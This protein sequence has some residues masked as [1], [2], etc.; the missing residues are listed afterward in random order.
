[1]GGGYSG[2]RKFLFSLTGCLCLLNRMDS[3]LLILPALIESFLLRGKENFRK[4]F[5]PGVLGMSPFA[6]WELF[7]L[8]Y[9]GFPFPNTAYAKLSS[10]IPLREYIRQGFLYYVDTLNRDPLTLLTI[11]VAMVSAV[12]AFVKFRERRVLC[13]ALGMALYCV[14][15]IRI[16]GDFMA[17]RFFS[18]TLFCGATLLARLPVERRVSAVL[19]CAALFYT[20][21]LPANNLISGEAYQNETID[22]RGIADERGWYY[23]STGLLRAVRGERGTLMNR[24]R[25]IRDAYEQMLTGEEVVE[26]GCV[27]FYGLTAGATLYVVDPFAL[28]DALIARLPAVYNPS[29]R[30]GHLTRRIPDGYIETL[31]TGENRFTD[32]RLG[33]YYEILHNIIS[34]DLFSLERFG[35]IVNMNLGKYNRLIDGGFYRKKLERETPLRY[36]TAPVKDGDAYDSDNS[37][38]FY[39]LDYATIP[40]G[41]TVHDET[42]SFY[43]ESDDEYSLILQKDG[44][45][46]Y[47]EAVGAT[48]DSGGMRI[49][50]VKPPTAVA[51]KGYDAV[52][53]IPSG[54]DYSFSIGC[55]AFGALSS[56]D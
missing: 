14:Y 16:G 32:E 25:W 46:V 17:G 2:K 6:L 53:L 10:G 39:N 20:V 48:E 9:Y 8:V 28:G 49:R 12:L 23:Q 50:Y 18:M 27:G 41:E 29:W 1:M 36:L 38:I 15:V 24:H 33:E 52:T 47:R 45:E 56:A 40:L 13:A 11:F 7:S 55:F 31:R 51:E 35:Q 43:A 19:V 5:L 37:W 30:I 26:V 34:G 54:G 22:E 42:F 44:E 4:S 21:L 3:V